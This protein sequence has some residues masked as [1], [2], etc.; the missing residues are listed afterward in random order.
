MGTD[1]LNERAPELKRDMDD[2]PLFVATDI[3]DHPVVAHEIDRTAE[4]PLYLGWISTTASLTI[5]PRMPRVWNVTAWASWQAC[6]DSI[7]EPLAHG[8]D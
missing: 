7:D 2:Q 3:K 8:R 4:L 1:E 6:D 5:P